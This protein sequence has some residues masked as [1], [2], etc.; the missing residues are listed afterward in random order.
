[1]P[2]PSL[3]SFI[4]ELDAQGELLRVT[5]AVSPILEIAAIADAQ[6]KSPA[7]TRSEVAA[8]FDPN[9]ADLG[10]KALLF[11]NVEGSDFPVAINLWGSYRR[12]EMVLGSDFESIAARIASLTRPVP[13]RSLGE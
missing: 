8:S 6:S 10:G 9:H 2:F 13:P 5:S 12:M 11:E 4:K 3:G 1:M 7:P